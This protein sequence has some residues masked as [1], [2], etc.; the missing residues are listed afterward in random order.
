MAMCHH[1][2]GATWHDNCSGTVTGA[3]SQRRSTMAVNDGERRSTM[4]FHSEPPPSHR[5]TT[6]G[7]P[8][9]YHRTTT[10]NQPTTGQ[11]WLTSSQLTGQWLGLGCHV[12]C[13]MYARGLAKFTIARLE[14]PTSRSKSQV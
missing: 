7:P 13:Q 11:W 1:L 8:S 6:T 14:T 2:S 9:D 12:A 4:T 10:D 3:T 5:R